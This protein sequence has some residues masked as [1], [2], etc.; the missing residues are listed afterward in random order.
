MV[1]RALLTSDPSVQVS[2]TTGDAISTKVR[3]LK[4]TQ[5]FCEIYF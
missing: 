4:N 5:L 3:P 1:L 2:D